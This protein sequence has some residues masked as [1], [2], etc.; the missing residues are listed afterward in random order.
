MKME[1]V[2]VVFLF[3]VIAA[4]GVYY[5]VRLKKEDSFLQKA[6]FNEKNDE[7]T[8]NE[9]NSTLY[10]EIISEDLRFEE[11]YVAQPDMFA[12]R[13]AVIATCM[14]HR[15]NDFLGSV[16]KGTYILVNAGGRV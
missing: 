4:C 13:K 9:K 15:L 3:F 11:S 16:T 1:K 7:D 6:S 2:V 10:S 5:M 8:L 12:Q 14:D